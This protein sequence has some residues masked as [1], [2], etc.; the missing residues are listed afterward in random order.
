MGTLT[1]S[2]G[3]RVAFV[4]GAASGIGRASAIALAA[5]GAIVF[6]TDIDAP[7]GRETVALIEAAGGQ[8]TFRGQDVVEEPRWAELVKRVMGLYGRLDILVNNAGIGT[9]GLITDVTLEQWNRQMDINVTSCFLGIKHALPAM[10]SPR[11][12]G[13]VGGSIINISSVAGLGGSAGMSAYCASKGAVRLLSKAVA[14]ECAAARDGIRC[15]SVHP[16]IIDTPIWQKLDTSG[17]L[18]A[19]L[20]PGANAIDVATVGAGAPVGFAGRPEDIAAG[21]VFLAS[22]ASRYMTGAEL[23]IDGGWTAH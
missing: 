6:A 16:G 14:M 23:V 11:P 19:A 13:H 4:T 21:I 17:V 12:D 1:G 5:E 9:S 7:G 2:L 18:S 20:T 22:D 10:R 15:N 8:A 3:G